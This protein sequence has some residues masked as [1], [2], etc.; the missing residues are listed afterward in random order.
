M[1][2]P[3]DSFSW[4]TSTEEREEREVDEAEGRGESMGETTAEESADSAASETCLRN[5]RLLGMAVE[6]MF[7]YVRMV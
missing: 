6:A 1:S 3:Y 5:T 2:L 7:G 4:E